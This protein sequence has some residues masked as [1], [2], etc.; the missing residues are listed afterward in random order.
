MKRL[1]IVAAL[2]G[3]AMPAL[4]QSKPP[5]QKPTPSSPQKPAPAPSRNSAPAVDLAYGAYQRGLYISAFQEAVKRIQAN[6]NDPAALTLLGELYSQGLGVKRD[7]KEAAS[8]YRLAAERGSPHAMAALGMMSLEGRGVPRDPKAARQWLEQAAEKGEPLACFNLAL[9]LLDN[10]SD[11][12]IAKAGRFLAT[13][14]RSEIAEAQHALGV[15]RAR[16]LGGLPQDKAE[17][18]LLYQRAAYNGS[19]AG[20]V[21]YAIV[22]FNGDGVPQNERLAARHFAHAAARGNAI[23]QNRFARM[24]VIGRGVPRNYLEALTW[25]MVAKNQGL[26]D[27]WLEEQLKDLPEADRVKA[28]QQA[29]DRAN[30]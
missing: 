7:P 29:H 14:A 19:L 27:P 21:E 8:W 28:Q 3:A 5:P 10:G 20:E 17:A 1:A 2:L 25:H 24:Y 26:N 15:L 4:G 30:L 22:L 6:Q 23:A 11:Q 18:A 12:D 16:G 9:V 13:A